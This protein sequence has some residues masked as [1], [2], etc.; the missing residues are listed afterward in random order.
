MS[1]RETI[2]ALGLVLP[3]TPSPKGDYVPVTIHGGVAYVSGQVCRVG[4]GVISGPVTDLTSPEVVLQAGQTCALRALSVLD[5]AVGLEN[6]ERILFV[7]GFVYG[8]EGFQNFSKVVDGASQVFIDV[9][10]E[11]GRHARSAVGVAGLP[12]GGLLELEVTGVIKKH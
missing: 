1:I 5:H 10:G 8:G 3:E 6:V 7:R 11:Q 4:E 9:F 12:G 2:S